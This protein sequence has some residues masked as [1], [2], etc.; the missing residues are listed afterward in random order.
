MSDRLFVPIKGFGDCERF[1][2]SRG[3]TS[4]PVFVWY[5]TPTGRI[6]TPYHQ[7]RLGQRPTDYDLMAAFWKPYWEKAGPLLRE[8]ISA[9]NPLLEMIPV[10][11]TFQG[12]NIPIPF[13]YGD[14]K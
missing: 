8:L 6:L 5:V 11:N 12:A 1:C 7:N 9:K 4:S 13:I 14:K 10:D 2:S 3:G